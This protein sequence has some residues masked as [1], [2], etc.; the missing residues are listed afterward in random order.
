MDHAVDST[1]LSV[2]LGARLKSLIF[3]RLSHERRAKQY[4]MK[5]LRTLKHMLEQND[6]GCPVMESQNGTNPAHL[7]RM[8][9]LIF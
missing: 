5:I 9:L 8:I 2:V 6:R 4:L 7:I 1:F 3:G